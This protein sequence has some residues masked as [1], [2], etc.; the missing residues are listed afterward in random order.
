MNLNGFKPYKFVQAR[1]V[2]KTEKESVKPITRHYTDGKIRGYQCPLCMKH[3]FHLDNYCRGCG[4]RFE[5][6]ERD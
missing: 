6:N 5:W 4:T 2:A 1:E 3:I